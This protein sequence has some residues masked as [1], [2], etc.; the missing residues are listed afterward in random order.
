[1]TKEQKVISKNSENKKQ[2]LKMKNRIAKLK[3]SVQGQE[4]KGEET[5]KKVKRKSKT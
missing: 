1:M 4:E 5:S 3:N 2:S